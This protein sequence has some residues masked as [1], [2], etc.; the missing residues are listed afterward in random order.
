V[1]S[2][3]DPLRSLISVF[4][5]G[6]ATFLSSSSSF[7]LIRA[8]WTPFQTHCYSEK[9][10]ADGIEPGTSGSAARKSDHWTTEAVKLRHPGSKIE[11][12][13][14]YQR[15]ILAKTMKRRNINSKQTLT[16]QEQ[17]L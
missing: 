4:Y 14:H 8:E 12:N 1:V 2:A 11:A 10:V 7:T 15:A 16:I 3:A 6:A 5:T 13:L 17:V 9:L